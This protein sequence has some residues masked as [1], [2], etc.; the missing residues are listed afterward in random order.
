MTNTKINS[1]HVKKI[2]KYPI[3]FETIVCEKILIADVNND[4]KDE[5]ILIR[6]KTSADSAVAEV[7]IYDLELNLIASD[8]W[9]G[10]AMDIIIADVNGNSENEIIISGRENKPIIR[11]YKYKN[12]L[13]LVS[14]FSWESPE[15]LY[16][17]AKSIYIDD[18]DNDGNTEIAVLAIAEGK[19]QDLGYAQLRIYSTDMKLKKSEEWNPMNG[20]ITRWGHCLSVTDIDGDGAYEFIA[21]INFNHDG[22]KRSDLRVFSHDLIVKNLCESMCNES[23]FATC[24]AI[25]D[26]NGD[27]KPEVV[28]GS[29]A[30]EGRWQGATNQ[31]TIFDNNLEPINKTQWRTFRHSWIWNMQIADVDLDG[32]K[33]I[34]IYG[35]TSLTGK[36]Q[37]DANTIG[38]I[39]IR[40]GKTLDPKDM[41]LW[42]SKPGE[43]TR[44]SRGIAFN[45]QF[46]I[47]TS[48]WSKRQNTSELEL[49]LLD[50]KHDPNAINEQLLFI[51]A[52]SDEDSATLTDF[53]L[54]ENDI[55]SSVALEA[56]ALCGDDRALETMGDLLGTSD[57]LLF[58][59]TVQLLRRFGARAIAQMRKAGFA[60]QDDWIIINPFDNTDN[61]GF[62]AAYPPEMEIDFDKFYAGKGRIVRWGKV[63]EDLWDDRRFD[64]NADLAY[65][66]FDSFERTG[67]EYSWNNLNLRSVAYLLTHVQCPEHKTAQLKIGSIDGVKVWVN[68]ELKFSNDITRGSSPDQDAFPV[69]FSK[70]TNT[71]ML[72][73]TSKS[74]NPFGFYFR[75]A[76]SDG[77]GI[78]ITY[79]QP[80]VSHIHNQMI[81]HSQ[82]DQLLE[83]DDDRLKYFAGIQ[84]AS[85]GDERGSDALAKLLKSKDRSV[86]A[87]SALALTCEG[88]KRGIETL[89]KTAP[90]QD[91]LFQISAGNA[92]ERMGD[93]R[94]SQFS[95]F[96]MKDEQGNPLVEIRVLNT[97]RGFRF[98]PMLKGDETA[99]VDVRTNMAFHL[100]DNISAKCASIASFGIREPEYRAMGIGAVA[101]RR[102][103]DQ[104][105][106]MGHSCT[107][108]ST[109]LRLVAHRLYCRT[110][111]FDRRPQTRFEKHLDSSDVDY[112]VLGILARDYKDADKEET[113]KLREQYCLTNVGPTESLPKSQFDERTKV[114]EQNGKLI[115]YATVNIPPFE[116]T[117][118]IE[119]F[120][121]DNNMRDRKI[122]SKTLLTGVHRYAL[123]EEKTRVMFYHSAPY[124]RDTLYSMGYDLDAS[125]RRHEWVGM[126]RIASLP[127]FLR[128]ISELLTL[129][130]KRS[131]HAGWQ[132][133]F[134]IN[135]ERLKATIIFGKDGVVSVEDGASKKADLTFTADDRIITALVSADGNIWEWYRQNIITTKPILNERIRDMLESLFPTM[136]CILGAWW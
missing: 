6:N 37:E 98:S 8:K 96:D 72:K 85:T 119:F 9:D 76:D 36:N 56:L 19:E 118:E 66:H 52:C 135:G 42:Q 31:L 75:I 109:G 124:L 41:L 122:A 53:A 117:A 7:I 111:F 68:G 39:A 43:D 103:N 84:L 45:K 95:P 92:L 74:R 26:I 88:D 14:Q 50:Y 125:M 86:K 102:A 32:N 62:D 17:T 104:M 25:D 1:F 3:D 38:E 60:I 51:K 34:I 108:V 70:G 64:I 49:R 93:R 23:M 16:A 87:D 130:I 59:R 21:L 132:G 133:S 113:L 106:E 15:N 97:Q 46:V 89:V 105:F 20:S 28:I 83:S 67:I 13:E 5:I 116:P 24:M 115:G 55:F 129:R 94:S 81:A 30:F 123:S 126:F 120:H 99:H 112:R 114:I 12:G 35:G 40:D 58:L 73:L 134:A 61:I 48:K 47:A 77:K 107:I 22:K 4:K 110:G 33:E 71:V 2:A 91:A 69:Q 136:P 128:E 131:V 78:P 65:V 29:G 11:T 79:K 63:G 127:V 44:P 10:D 100:G 101:L 54:P 82:L 18:I 57:K 90:S 80:E 121:I 27:G